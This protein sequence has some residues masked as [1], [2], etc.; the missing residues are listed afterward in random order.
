M[1][2]SSQLL[3][4]HSARQRR[5]QSL[6]A[7][8]GSRG[9]TFVTL[10]HNREPGVASTGPSRHVSVARTPIQ[11]HRETQRHVPF[12]A[13]ES[14][15]VSLPRSTPTPILGGNIDTTMG[16]DTANDNVAMSSSLPAEDSMFLNNSEPEELLTNSPSPSPPLSSASALAAAQPILIP[17]QFQWSARSKPAQIAEAERRG[18]EHVRQLEDAAGA[19][20]RIADD[21]WEEQDDE[22][23]EERALNPEIHSSATADGTSDEN[24]P[25]PFQYEPEPIRSPPTAA[26]VHPN[27]AVYILYLLV[28]WMHT[29]FH[30]PFRACSALLAVV[31][32]AFQASGT[33]IDPPIYTTLPSV[34]THLDA[35]PSFRVCP[36]CP[37]CITPYPAS[38]TTDAHCTKCEHPLFRPAPTSSQKR[39]TQNRQPYLKFPMKSLE[40]QIIDMLAIPGVE[41]VMDAWRKKKRIPGEFNDIFDGDVCKELPGHDGLPFFLPDQEE[42]ANGELRIG[43][44]LG[45]DWYDCLF[46]IRFIIL[47]FLI[48]VLIPAKSDFGFSY[49]RAHVFQ[50]GQLTAASK[51]SLCQVLKSTWSYFWLDTGHLI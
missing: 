23:G 39:H 11:N 7:L 38:T 24:N 16:L 22:E 27:P 8:S 19:S 18:L 13:R 4:Q 26:E 12:T 46:H 32:L 29:Q 25:D 50:C 2:V 3:Q 51:V 45:V 43:V 30:L 35:E 9:P 1:L 14:Q 41:D 36:V 44:S 31:A 17:Q 33:P 40:E 21:D 37:K 48:K 15:L 5:Q 28:L 49:V 6:Q 47:S 20:M 42:V 34:I 10:S